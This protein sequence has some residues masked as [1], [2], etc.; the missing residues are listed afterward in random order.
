MLEVFKIKRTNTADSGRNTPTEC[1]ENDGLNSSLDSSKKSPSLRRQS[2]QKV[3]GNNLVGT[4]VNAL[5]E[6]VRERTKGEVFE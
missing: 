6:L 2:S 5:L 1:Q 4:D 3:T